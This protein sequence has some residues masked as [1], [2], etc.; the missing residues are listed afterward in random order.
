M[1]G[2]QTITTA[3]VQIDRTGATVLI[4]AP[5]D[6]DS[7]AAPSV[8]IHALASDVLSG[9]ASVA[10]NGTSAQLV[11]GVAS[12]EVPLSIG[13]NSHR[14]GRGTYHNVN[15]QGQP[16]RLFTY[17]HTDLT[18]SSCSERDCVMY[19]KVVKGTPRYRLLRDDWNAINFVEESPVLFLRGL[20]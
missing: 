17:I 2:N 19:S 3:T 11:D 12:C 1:A 14:F 16:T 20:P 10:C 8:M 5:E 9:V 13:A 15:V 7:T 18:G 6:G 4:T